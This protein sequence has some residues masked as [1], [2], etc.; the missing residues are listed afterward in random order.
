[1]S[2]Y[3]GKGMVSLISVGQKPGSDPLREVADE[4]K[5]H[6]DERVGGVVLRLAGL[7]RRFT[8]MEQRMG[9]IETML[10]AVL[11]ELQTPDPPS[12]GPVKGMHDVLRRPGGI[13]PLPRMLELL[14]AQRDALTLGARDELGFT[15]LSL[16][17]GNR[18]NAAFVAALIAAC[19][20]AAAVKDPYGVM[21]VNA[22]AFYGFPPAIIEALLAAVPAFDP[23]DA[24]GYTSVFQALYQLAPTAV[25]LAII[26]DAVGDPDRADLAEEVSGYLPLHY[27]LENDFNGACVIAIAEAHPIA[28]K[29][30]CHGAL[31]VH[32]ALRHGCGIEVFRAIHS[33]A[34]DTLAAKDAEGR[35]PFEIA[36]ALTLASEA[37]AVGCDPDVLQELEHFEHYGGGGGGEEGEGKVAAGDGDTVEQS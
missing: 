13:V 3:S 6:V 2:L 11:R 21:P 4:M 27:A 34:P 8:A 31:P 16:A 25:V 33:A 37:G 7:E 19:P 9:S 26:A 12:L 24:S 14:A 28:A 23:A 1:M 20:A 30:V 36:T 18:H 10:H 22:A 29:T 32:I 5:A 35:S 17:L 15:P